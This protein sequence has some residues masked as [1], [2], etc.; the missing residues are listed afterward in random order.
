MSRYRV[1]VRP[2]VMQEIKHLPGNV[3][4]RVKRAVDELADEPRRARTR[5]METRQTMLEV[6][7]LRL[8]D[9]RVI[10]AINEDLQQVQVLAI[11]QRPPYDYADLDELLDT[12]D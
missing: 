5:A 11:R 2:Q 8:D 7:R 3:R 12:L 10:Y 6:R 4:Q 9:W 1:R